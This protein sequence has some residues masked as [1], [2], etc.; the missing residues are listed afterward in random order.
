M[1]D[2]SKKISELPTAANVAS[3]DRILVLRDPSGT[4][5]VRTVN[6]NIFC[7]NITISNS[8]PANSS[9]NGIAGTIRFD[10]SYIYVCVSNNTWKRS[11]LSTW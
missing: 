11:T 1:T 3:T 2:N 10:S 5:S 8:V 9:A 7:A 4:P 6:V